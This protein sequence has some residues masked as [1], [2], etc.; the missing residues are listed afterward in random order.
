MADYLSQ[1]TG[2]EIDARLAKV[3]QL[4]TGKQ[5]KLVSG[6]NIKTVNGQSV[7]GSGNIEV[8]AG[9]TN[10]VKY[11]A[12]TLTEEQKAQARANIDAASLADI[13][14]MDFVT[15]ASLPTA[16]ASTM[17]HIYLIGPDANNNYDRYF[18]Q[19][20]GSSYS[21]VSLGSTQIDL[22][23]YATK[24]EVTELEHDVDNIELSI[25]QD[26]QA[27]D[28]SDFAV[29]DGKYIDYSSPGL[30]RTSAAWK[31][32]KFVL[33][34]KILSGIAVLSSSTNGVYAVGFYSDANNLG[35]ST[36]IS[37]IQA[38]VEN[39]KQ[40]A[41]NNIPN[42]CKAVAICN[43]TEL[44][45]ASFTGTSVYSKKIKDIE[46]RL[47][48][49]E[50]DVDNAQT[51]I[52]N[53]Q[54]DFNGLNGEVIGNGYETEIE[55]ITL[56]DGVTQKLGYNAAPE[57][58]TKITMSLLTRFDSY[59]YYLTSDADIWLVDAGQAY[60]SVCYVRDANPIS[61]DS[62]TGT[63]AGRLRKTD[64]NL[65]TSDNPLS[66]NAGDA[67][68]V[69]VTA[70]YTVDVGSKYPIDTLNGNLPLAE[71]HIQQV[72][73]AISADGGEMYVKKTATQVDVY[74]RLSNGQY[75]HY[76]FVKRYKT[77]SSG[78]YPSFYDNWGIGQVAISNL[79]DGIMQ[80]QA[81]LFAIGEAELAVSV[82]S[83][84]DAEENVYVG[85]SAHGFENIVTG[86]NGREVAILVNNQK[87]AEDAVISLT[88]VEKVEVI[89]HTKLCQAYTNS[90]PW[91]DVTKHWVWEKGKMSCTSSV[92]ILRT[93]T[94]A[95][96]QFG[97]FC[98][99]RHWL[100]NDNNNYLTNKAVKNNLPYKVW[101]V[102]D[103][104]SASGLS[105]PDKDCTRI[106]EYGERGIGFSMSIKS[107]TTKASG[108]MFIGPPATAYNKI[109]FDMGRS[110]TPSVDEV[111][112]ATQTWEIYK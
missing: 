44:G 93:L 59:Y 68:I 38:S 20:D 104:W 75:I 92:K 102:E 45:T 22:S 86:D 3:P 48:D 99:Y 69:T 34:G 103:G 95:F 29:I 31:T 62:I 5:D 54:Y 8:Q 25:G 58:P 60:L 33:D 77:Y 67:V 90:N 7:L 55:D 52:I 64:N 12:Q 81:N 17:G 6:T 16:S 106:V 63:S 14:D 111:L 40:Y 9:D 82:P 41:I 71:E 50:E 110:F 57:N 105:M 13:N 27:I 74:L 46:D 79:A 108:G 19:E 43:K 66:L 112:E 109:Y 94:I 100:G 73:D 21:W 88:P 2:S 18:T 83:G 30:L 35:T 11:V 76:P 78:Q 39:L 26:A 4:E 87:V 70:G 1:F 80:D 23:T 49:V 107:E 72:M 53:L 28:L 15:A 65:P 47:K 24:A 91:A 36:W 37:G 85:G 51:D 96:S 32:Y 10:A 98:V 56:I 89:Q 101:N 97:M 61:G 42:G 84:V